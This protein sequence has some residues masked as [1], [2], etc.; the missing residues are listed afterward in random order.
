MRVLVVTGTGTEVG[1]TVVTA[2]IAAIATDAGLRVGVVKVAQTGIGSSEESDVEVVT[3]L[4]GVTDV[5]ELVRYP[6]P[7]APATAARRASIPTRSLTSMVAAIRALEDRDLVVVEGAGGLLVRLDV[8]DA[9]ISDIAAELAAEVVVVAA[10]GLGTLNATALTCEALRTRGLPCAGVVIGSW[11]SEPDLA[12]LANLDDFETYAHA[13]LL[14]AIPQD[15]G[16]SSRES[17]LQIAGRSL[18]HPRWKT[19]LQQPMTR[20]VS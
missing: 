17:F 19:W 1:K 18:S 9:T 10:A 4:S 15:S 11:P 7:L 14:G 3:R 8:D 12:A 16:S 6:E 5:H 2:A 13:P 20:G